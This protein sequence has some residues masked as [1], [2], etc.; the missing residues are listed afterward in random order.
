MFGCDPD[1]LNESNMLSLLLIWRLP[2]NLFPSKRIQ[3]NP[4]H[5]RRPV[6]FKTVGFRGI[7]RN[8]APN[9]KVVSQLFRQLTRWLS[10][11]SWLALTVCIPFLL[12]FVVGP[13][14]DNRSL[15]RLLPLSMLFANVFFF[16]K[17][18]YL[19]LRLKHFEL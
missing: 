6:I 11:G 7:G 15:S 1:T 13:N 10:F 16:P 5:W 4:E 14:K 9:S 3:R 2:C 19:I 18:Y 8:R 17:L 12:F